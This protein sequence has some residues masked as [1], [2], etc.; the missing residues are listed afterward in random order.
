MFENPFTPLFGGRPDFFFGREEI[1]Q[2]FDRA[3]RDYGSDYRAL[4]I[5]GSRGYGKTTLLEQLSSQA[6]KAGRTVID[7]GSDNPIA[8]IMRHLVPYSE[9]TKTIDPAIEV[10]VLG[11]GGAIRGGSSSRTVRYDRDDFEYLF[12]KTCAKEGA[13]LFLT[14][15]EIQKAS[16]E[17]VALIAESFQM[18]SRKGYDVMMAIAGLPS[19]HEPIIQ[20]DGC[21]FLRRAPHEKLGPLTPADI[22]K[23]F[24]ISFA[25][26]KGFSIEEAA[27]AKLVSLSKG[28]PY[29]TQ[30]LGYY[31]IDSI[32]QR[33]PGRSYRAAEEDV[34]Q[35]GPIALEAYYHRALEPMVAVLPRSSVEYL[36]AMALELDGRRMA[37]TR[38]IAERLGKEQKQLSMTREALL[39]DDLV[40]VPERGKLAFKIPY[41]ADYLV[42]EAPA[43]GTDAS[44]VME[45]GM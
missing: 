10:S 12:L 32:N 21:T 15:D 39:A 37:S 1:L 9:A 3:M 35:V 18:A 38:A 14:I 36:R 44:V 43:D 17:D 11:T 20:A 28:H 7:V 23:A 34:A 2:R 24:S 5:T 8:G 19:A 25:S 31:L 16:L 29:L 27:F 42:R 33:G 22:E 45:W 13:K 40:V 41:L 30:L 4:F 26:I 6:A